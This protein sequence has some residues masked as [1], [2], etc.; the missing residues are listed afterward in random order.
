MDWTI[1]GQA[2]TDLRYALGFVRTA[3][4]QLRQGMVR[5]ALDS[6]E[7]AEDGGRRAEESL[8]RAVE[9]AELV[10]EDAE[11]CQAC[12]GIAH[13]GHMCSRPESWTVEEIL[14]RE[15]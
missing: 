9:E 15:G 1:A 6:L 7:R 12:G 2:L 11:E 4:R 5:A 13:P 10:D 3:A 14:A 8:V